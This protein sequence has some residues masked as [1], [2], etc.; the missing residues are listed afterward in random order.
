MIQ[1][2]LLQETDLLIIYN[3]QQIIHVA[4]SSESTVATN[5]Q[6]TVNNNIVI[7][8]INRVNVWWL[9]MNESLSFVPGVMIDGNPF[10]T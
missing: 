8:L 10:K 1:T 5:N 7:F 9:D 2:Q 3:Y 4:L 6:Y